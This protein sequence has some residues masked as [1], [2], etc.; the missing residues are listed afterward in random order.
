M[1]KP[2]PGKKFKYD[3]QT[4]LKVRE[5]KE[6][7]EQEQFA[8]KQRKLFEEQKKEEDIKDNKLNKED[9]LRGVFEKGPITDFTKVLTRKAHLEVL[10][11]DLEKQV[12]KVIEAGKLLEEQRAKLII[13]MKDRKVMEKHKEKKLVE[14]D[15]L[16]LDLET[17]FLDEIATQR[18]IRVKRIDKER[19]EK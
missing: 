6:K 8:R 2:K 10:K 5:I 16:M 14:Y 17:K 7:K 1:A 9:D 18:F 15:K 4:V 19:E 11:D 3:L 12:E 13:S